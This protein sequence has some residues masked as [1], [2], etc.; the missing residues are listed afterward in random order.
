MKNLLT[1][2]VLATLAGCA[3]EFDV[4]TDPDGPSVQFPAGEV[5][6]NGNPVSGE[7][8]E[9]QV[10]QLEPGFAIHREEVRL[11]PYHTR[12]QKLSRVAGV[13]VDDPIFDELRQSRYDLG[14]HNY[15]QGI[16]PDL[17]WTANKMSIWVRGLRPVCNS[18]AMASN[19]PFLPEHL[20]EML[21]AA[22]G[23]EAT[24][25]DLA[26]YESILSDVTLSDADRYEAVCLAVLTSTEFVAQ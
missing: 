19:Y 14:D 11:L 13:S 17:S 6:E 24:Q 20:N 22:Y 26:D 8:G 25:E 18:E 21:Q 16:G 1:I 10:E 9:Q 4:F 7:D 5:D 3:G 2:L 23:R 15:G 12:M